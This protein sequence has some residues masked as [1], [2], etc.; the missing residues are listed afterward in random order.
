MNRDAD[1]SGIGR[2]LFRTWS[3]WIWFVGAAAWF[4]VAALSL[5]HHALG[6][7]VVAAAISALFLAA[8][9]F[10]RRLARRGEKP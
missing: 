2:G 1:Q 9:M 4:L 8:G 5:H 7:G 6:S 10:F 3:V